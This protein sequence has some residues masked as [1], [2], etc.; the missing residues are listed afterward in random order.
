M[1]RVG[2][3]AGAL[4]LET[5]TANERAWY[6]LGDTKVPCNWQAAGFRTPAERD[7][8][9]E[10]WVRLVPVGSPAL[11]GTTLEIEAEGEEVAQRVAARL[12]IDRTGSVSE[13]LW[14]LVVGEDEADDPTSAE[15]AA[16]WL[17]E[18]PGPVWDIVRD[19]VLKCS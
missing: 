1:A 16:S 5:L 14:R 15:I 7:V 2:R 10:R 6:L 18:M 11:Q 17:F 4:L 3:L 13:R 12:T 9:H 19:A 8:K